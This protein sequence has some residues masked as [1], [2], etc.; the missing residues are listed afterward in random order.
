[1]AE[2][3]VRPQP[4]QDQGQQGNLQALPPIGKAESES[5]M[6]GF[7]DDFLYVELHITRA[8]DVDHGPDKRFM[9]RLRTRISSLLNGQRR[10]N[11]PDWPLDK[12][13]Q[14]F[15]DQPIGYPSLAQYILSEPG[16]GFLIFRKFAYLQTR[17]LLQKQ[18]RI[19]GLEKKLRDL[20]RLAAASDPESVKS[21]A[22]DDSNSA[23]QELFEEIDSRLGDYCMHLLLRLSF[24]SND[25]SKQSAEGL[26]RYVS[27]YN[28]LV[29]DDRRFL[30]EAND[31]VSLAEDKED[32]YLDVAIHNLIHLCLPK[33]IVKKLLCRSRK[34]DIEYAGT[35][36]YSDKRVDLYVRCMLT[37][38]SVTL[39][40]GPA[41]VLLFVKG[42]N[43]LK[44]AVIIVATVGFS[45]V[46]NIA[47][48]GKRVEIFAAT[49]AEPDIHDGSSKI[50]DQVER[51]S[52]ECTRSG[53]QEENLMASYEAGYDS[54]MS[55]EYNDV[56]PET[57]ASSKDERYQQV[58]PGS[59]T[60]GSTSHRPSER[61]GAK[62]NGSPKTHVRA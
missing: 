56:E 14:V 29:E 27:H 9:S 22:F 32:G 48:R 1:M 6:E 57:A 15:H 49:C 23:R 25:S 59:G 2:R 24:S 41:S 30:H 18:E 20:D 19:S 21:R 26:A 55:D 33:S 47:T 38:T 54:F 50:G 52:K 58:A 46:C 51:V 45:M 37:F 10:G 42:H 13:S 61:I 5:N 34:P 3:S 8:H 36:Y 40:M 16:N 28:C 7:T 43:A 44:F 53:R 17:L 12:I 11:I 60:L 35:T 39:L 31:H 62:D 4:F